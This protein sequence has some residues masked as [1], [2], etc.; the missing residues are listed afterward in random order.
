MGAFEIVVIYRLKRIKCYFCLT[1]LW[2]M[3]LDLNSRP[4]WYQFLYFWNCFASHSEITLY[5]V[6]Q[7]I[8]IKLFY[9]GYLPQC[10]ATNPAIA[11]GIYSFLLV[12]VL[13]LSFSS[14]FFSGVDSR[15]A[16]SRELGASPRVFKFRKHCA[17]GKRSVGTP[18]KEEKREINRLKEGYNPNRAV[19]EEMNKS[20]SNIA[21]LKRKEFQCVA[22]QPKIWIRV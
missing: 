12:L 11:T 9:S 5:F 21:T 10:F 14:F 22:K 6:N 2:S 4:D 13:L 1:C 17:G 15:R 7:N 19:A 18:R 20:L 16:R 8:Q 3:W